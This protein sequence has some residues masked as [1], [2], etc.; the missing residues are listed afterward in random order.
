MKHLSTLFCLFLFLIIS[1][2][3]FAQSN[4]P[5]VKRFEDVSRTKQYART[6]PRKDNNGEPAALVLVQVLATDIHVD[7]TANYLLGNVEK[8]ASEYWVYMAAGAKSLEVH[9][10]G[11]EKLRI[12][13]S[14]VSNGEITSLVKQCTYELVIALPEVAITKSMEQLINEM[15]AKELAKQVQSSYTETSEPTVVERVPERLPEVEQPVEIKPKKEVV[16]KDT[17]PTKYDLYAQNAKMKTLVLGQ[18]GYSVAPQLSYGAMVGQ[19]YKGIGWYVSARSN[20]QFNGITPVASCDED[21]NVD[22]ILPFYSGNTYTSH[23]TVHGG[24]MMNVLEK[25]TK[26]KFNTLGFYVGGGYGQ[27]QLLA[28]TTTGEWIK[29]SPTSHNGFA[30]NLGLFGSVAGVTLNIGA[31]TV[32]FKYLDLEMGIG[33]MF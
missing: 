7:F 4:G 15:I 21:G 19:M 26:N 1:I 18:L 11:F 8:K 16:E 9:C 31:S 22:G 6:Q 29:Y 20:F 14:E 24:F 27:R 13:F 5:T 23:Y 17:I 28:E 25:V 12:N 30:A 3:S 2:T 32:N 33:F 10:A